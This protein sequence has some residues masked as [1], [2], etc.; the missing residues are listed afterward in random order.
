MSTHN[1][2]FHGE[3]RKIPACQLKTA[4]YL[5]HWSYK[6]YADYY[7]KVLCSKGL[8]HFPRIQ[9]KLFHITPNMTTMEHKRMWSFLIHLFPYIYILIFLTCFPLKNSSQNIFMSKVKSPSLDMG[10][11][12]KVF[13]WKRLIHL[14]YLLVT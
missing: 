3:R 6:T 4:H 7:L 5:E 11:L 12:C 10:N 9:N 13:F 14:L 8:H 1:I 2:Y